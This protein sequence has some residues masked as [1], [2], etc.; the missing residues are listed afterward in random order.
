MGGGDQLEKRAFGLGGCSFSHYSTYK[1]SAHDSHSVIFDK[2]I[3]LKSVLAS[4][5]CSVQE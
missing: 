2:R 5:S 3:E 1:S 4:V